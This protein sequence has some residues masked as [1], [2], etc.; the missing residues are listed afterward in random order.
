MSEGL[1]LQNVP[2]SKI[3]INV[4]NP[5]KDM[6]DLTGLRQSI[7]AQ[8]LIQPLRVRQY[9][10]NGKLELIAGERRFTAISAAIEA[11][12]LPKSYEIPV[13]V[14]NVDD[15]TTIQI[16]F[17]ENFHRKDLSD[18]EQAK[19]FKEYLDRF[20]DPKAIDDLSTK[21]G[22]DIQYIRRRAK[23][24]D[25]DA[26]ILKLWE[27]GKLMFGHLE[28]L[29]RVSPEFH[30]EIAKEVMDENLTIGELKQYIDNQKAT[31]T[32]A[33]F[34]YKA[35]GCNTCQFSTKVQKSLF[36]EE[37]FKSD[38]LSCTNPKCFYDNQ[39]KALPENWK[40]HPVVIEQK[41]NGMAMKEGFTGFPLYQVKKACAKCENFVTLF[42]NNGTPHYAPC[43]NGDKVC[44]SK[45]YDS[46]SVEQK[47]DDVSPEKKA[48]IRN[49]NLAYDTA[50]RF[51]AGSLPA[52]IM[53]K[54]DGIETARMQL[55]ALIINNPREWHSV[56]EQREIKH[57]DFSIDESF[58]NSVFEMEMKDVQAFIKEVSV[59]MVMNQR[60][61]RLKTRRR[62]AD[63]FGLHIEKE[64]VLTEAY[65]KRKSKDDLIALNKKH[66]ILD[67]GVKELEAYKK[68]ALIAKLLKAKL[69][70]HVPDEI[71][72]VAKGK[73][74][75][76]QRMTKIKDPTAG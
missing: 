23:V 68:S 45:N 48:Q 20:E 10:G 15:D 27:S 69:E 18:V 70:G 4:L 66:K 44:Y 65:M 41:T 11:G 64:F 61:F 31:F 12:E 9:K 72:A 76:V 35:A 29:L 53:K 1:K 24:V 7:V 60:H 21:T 36:G 55:L 37:G 40:K 67:A 26:S 2:A 33:V 63:M 25:L 62:I 39:M 28:Q 5:R 56:M 52:V 30:A 54:A 8:G 13:L 19:A 58:I 57:S 71:A 32:N 73:Y 43:C 6:G 75:K 16:M 34:D 42:D 47:K 38:K 46:K 50:E 49:E 74:D 51:Y 14:E 59:N 3:V 17:I 22:I